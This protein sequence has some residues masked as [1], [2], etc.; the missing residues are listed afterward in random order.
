MLHIHDVS[1]NITDILSFHSMNSITGIFTTEWIS[2][3]GEHLVG[4]KFVLQQEGRLVHWTCNT[5]QLQHFF[6]VW[7]M[8]P[9]SPEWSLLITRYEL[10]SS[11]SMS[12]ESTMS[13]KSSSNWLKCGKAEIQHLTEN[14]LFLFIFCVT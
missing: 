1:K 7:Q 3:A 14:L 5:I 12:H 10:R 6:W 11:I 9:N 13:K 2:A 8:A 4:D